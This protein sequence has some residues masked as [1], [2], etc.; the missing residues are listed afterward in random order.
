MHTYI[1]F[2]KK[3][4]LKEIHEKIQW[5]V[6]FR[7][8]ITKAITITPQEE[9]PYWVAQQKLKKIVQDK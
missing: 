9:D 5:R 4:I 3:N 7:G 1:P 6:P 2:V 8:G